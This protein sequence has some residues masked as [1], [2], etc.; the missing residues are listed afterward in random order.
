MSFIAPE[1]SR[2]VRCLKFD[3]LT[4]ETSSVDV[5]VSKPPCEAQLAA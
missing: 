5:W 2:I 3:H 4:L 1:L